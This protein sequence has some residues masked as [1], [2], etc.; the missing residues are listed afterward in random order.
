MPNPQ[1]LLHDPEAL[2]YL[3]KKHGRHYSPGYWAKLRHLGK[4]PPFYLMNNRPAYSP[5]HLDEHAT[6]PRIRGPFRKPSEAR[7]NSHNA[8]APSQT[9]EAA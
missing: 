8:C 5:A 6:T 1:D 3:A 7:K 2:D 4:G 9:V